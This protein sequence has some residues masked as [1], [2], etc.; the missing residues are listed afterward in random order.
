MTRSLSESSKQLVILRP[1]KPE[2]A[3]F[4]ME[5]N[6][7]DEIAEYV[8][9]NPKKV[10]LEE[11]IQWMKNLETEKNTKRFIVESNG[12]QAGTVIISNIDWANSTANLNI[13]LHKSARR[14][15]IGKKSIKSAL[16]ECFNKMNIFCVT[17]HILPFN[18]PS[19]ALFES[20]GFENEGTLRSRVIKGCKRY[21]LISFSLTYDDYRQIKHSN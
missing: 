6:N 12:S 3:S 8:V 5:L 20:C 21:D 1:I 16:D 10:T 13:K 18:S 15:G 19:I 2:D 7:D 9:G 4:L 17:A 11:Q 14:K